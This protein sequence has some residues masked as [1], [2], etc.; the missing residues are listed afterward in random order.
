M[1]LFSECYWKV[2]NPFPEIRPILP[3]KMIHMLLLPELHVF[4]LVVVFTHFAL[5]SDAVRLG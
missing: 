2:K 3:L 1:Y 5:W 4:S